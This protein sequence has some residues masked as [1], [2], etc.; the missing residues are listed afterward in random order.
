MHARDLLV[1]L[2]DI[3]LVYTIPVHL[4][5]SKSQTHRDGDGVF[6]NLRPR[7][8]V[9]VDG[10]WGAPDVA[11][12]SEWPIDRGLHNGLC[13]AVKETKSCNL[14]GPSR[15]PDLRAP[16]PMI[17]GAEVDPMP[18]M[19]QICGRRD[20]PGGYEVRVGDRIGSP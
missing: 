1:L 6:N 19:A 17:L 4:E 11:K 15:G 7:Q 18:D 10:S 8:R 16:R 9:R 2:L 20:R 3:F 5:I 12:G 14:F 13:L